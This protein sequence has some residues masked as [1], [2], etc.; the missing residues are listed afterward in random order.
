MKRVDTAG[1]SSGLS[2]ILDAQTHEYT[3]GKFSKGFK[4]LIHGQDEYID[5]W[6]GISVGPGQHAVIALSQTRVIIVTLNNQSLVIAS[7]LPKLC[8][9]SR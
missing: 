9:L 4:V 3:Q 1:V 5:E 2:V 7:T 8:F 6:E